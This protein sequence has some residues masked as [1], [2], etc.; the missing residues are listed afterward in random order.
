MGT[1]TI[2]EF[3]L[4]SAKLTQE[5]FQK[6]RFKQKS[7]KIGL[8]NEL[9]NF[10][11]RIG[12]SPDGVSILVKNGHEVIFEK[13]AGLGSKFTDL[14][15][16]NAGAKIVYSRKEVFEA[17]VI[18]KIEPLTDE[19]FG[20]LSKSKTVISTL[21]VST[22]GKEY[23][24]KFNSTKATGIAF[25]FIQDK[26]GNFPIIRAMSEIAGSTVMLIAAE[27]LSSVQNGK[28]VIL[29]G[30]TGVPPTSVVILGAG[31]VAEYAARTALGLGA[32]IKVFDSYIYRLQR[33]K[34]AVGQS[35]YTSIIDTEKL[36][37]AISEADV[38]IGAMRGENGFAPMV[39]SDEMVS[40]MKSNSVLIDVAIDQGGCFE[41]SQITNHEFPTFKKY[42]VIHYCV[43]NIAS[44]V[45]STASTALSNIFTPFI[46]KAGLIGGI[47]EMIFANQWFMKGVYAYNGNITN[48]TIAHKFDLRFRDLELLL[49]ARF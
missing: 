27:Y 22:L 48:K 40:K 34:Y 35:I 15:Y 6:Q 47:E 38:V 33:L 32:E 37:K 5:S 28:G 18:L 14:E 25:E 13:S 44:R 41:T 43:P 9:S 39:V 1:Q 7:L 12:L 21:N 2:K 4:Q 24:E 3:A 46:I 42:D 29:G 30:V 8:P 20:L 16:Q 49:A 17:D 45:A 11:N 19:E 31:T 26:V 10:E 23:F 36:S